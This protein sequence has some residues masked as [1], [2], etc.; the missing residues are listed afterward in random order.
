[1]TVEKR[2]LTILS[3]N[4]FCTIQRLSS[5]FLTV[6][7]DRDSGAH[8]LVLV[9]VDDS[10]PVGSNL[11]KVERLAQVD[12]V[13]DV[14]LEARS[15][16]A[17]RGLEELGTQSGVLADGVG[18]LVDVGTGSFA[19][20]RQR[21]DGGDSLVYRTR[22]DVSDKKRREPDELGTASK[23][24]QSERLTCAS[25]ALAASLESSDDQRPTVRIRSLLQGVQ[26][27][28]R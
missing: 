22:K 9:H 23:T 21:V 28:V 24:R 17:N 25:M 3:E 18:D 5:Q 6:L 14:L 15:S 1:M 16:E 8:L 27:Q 2:V 12:K 19:N 7:C 20:G 26:K 4:R 10:L 11:G 13:E